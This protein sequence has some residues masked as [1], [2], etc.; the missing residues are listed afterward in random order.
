MVFRHIEGFELGNR[1]AEMQDKY[2]VY[3]GSTNDDEDGRIAGASQD[4]VELKTFSL[5]VQNEWVIGFGVRFP[6]HS[7][8]SRWLDIFRGAD[9]Q[10]S[11]VFERYG[12]AP[13][14]TKVA[15]HKDRDA[16]AI[17]TGTTELQ[18]DTWYYFE[19]KFEPIS[20]GSY[21]LRINEIEEFS[22]T[23]DLNLSTLSGADIFY[24][25]G[26]NG[27]GCWLDDMYILDTTG[28]ADEGN[29]FQGDAQV[30]GAFVTGD[31]DSIEWTASS[32]AN[33]TCIDDPIN[34]Y[35]T[36][37]YVESNTDNALDLYQFEDI[38]AED[39]PGDIKAVQLNGYC[40][41]AAAGSRKFKFCHMEESATAVNVIDDEKTVALAGAAAAK[42]ETTILHENPHTG[43][44]WTLSDFN[45]SMFG[46]KII[47]T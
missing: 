13:Y 45:S 30:I 27:W 15:L 28:T 16:A 14:H 3:D 35:S 41:L 42:A 39:L 2:A 24:F 10:C 7:S 31:G 23:A 19:F 9:R 25:Y 1:E 22:G 6:S 29:D 11:L 34:Q 47:P 40:A 20:S 38:A 4:P 33:Y 8:V 18:E 44:A 36:S 17:V 46:F 43:A 21:T 5:T 32:G 37:D 12:A 26:D